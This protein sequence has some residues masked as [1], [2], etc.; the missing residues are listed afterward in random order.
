VNI[1]SAQ[2][3]KLG[4]D[5]L[6]NEG[7]I[8]ADGRLRVTQSGSVLR[9]AGTIAVATGDTL[10]MDVGS[11]FQAES[12]SVM[13][14]LLLLSDATVQGTGAVGDVVSV[15]GSIRPGLPLG[16]LTASSVTMDA[17]SGLTIEVGGTTPG[18]FDQLAVTGNISYAGSLSITGVPP[19]AG[20]IC[21]QVVPIITDNST[22][23]RGAFSKIFGLVQGPV[24]SWR[25]YNPANLFELVGYTPQAT[26]F[27]NESSLDVTEGAGSVRYQ[28]CLGSTRPT[29]D[30]V[31]SLSRA[32]DQIEVGPASL[33]FPVATWLLPQ[34]VTVTPLNDGV[35]EPLHSDTVLSAV[36]SGDPLYD[37]LF[38]A[39]LPVVITDNDGSASSPVASRQ[40]TVR[41]ASPAHA[42]RNAWV[43]SP[44]RIF[45]R[46]WV[47]PSPFVMTTMSDRPATDA[48]AKQ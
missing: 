45:D 39:P 37:D 30:V 31:V 35:V 19:F 23:A 1:P 22:V 10:E 6:V 8:V 21:G 25:I 28:V 42:P 18:T 11:V 17:R 16:T 15:S 2:R 13:T 3:V 26:I 34:T 9:N 4:L 20:G 47:P 36:T 40:Q 44:V 5:S 46:S 41:P 29:A 27:V 14:G 32:L 48:T 33:T 7:S 43:R 24:Y 38:V 12:G